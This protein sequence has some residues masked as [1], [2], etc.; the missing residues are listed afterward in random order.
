VSCAPGFL[1]LSKYVAGAS[2]NILTINKTFTSGKLSLL[3]KGNKIE[4][5]YDGFMMY[6][7]YD[8]F[9]N[10]AT[11]HGLYSR[12]DDPTFKW[13]NLC[14]KPIDFIPFRINEDF[15]S[16]LSKWYWT[17]ETPAQ[18]YSQTFST[19]IK[20][21]GSQSFRVELRN[22][23]PDV[24]SSKRCEILL[25]SEQPLEEHWYGVSIYLPNGGTEDYAIDTQ[26]EAL[27][28]WHNTP[29]TSEQSVSPP[30]SLQT[31]N[32]RYNIVIDS[33]AGR[34]S[35]QSAPFSLTQTITDIGDYTADKG[36]WVQWVFHVRWG[37]LSNQNPITEVYKDGLLVYQNNGTPN[38]MN[39]QLGV[40]QKLGIYKWPWHSANNGGSILTSRVVYYDNYWMI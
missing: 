28:Q 6:Q 18:S 32:G 17:K 1:Q 15:E 38:T 34:M 31:I 14:F 35:T 8:S 7:G 12:G 21:S 29:D 24:A 23:D 26:P 9:N 40:Y 33:D 22:T 36:K 2:T 4:I 39:D 10:T 5:Y 25:P 19:G 13:D 3:L 16:N 30:L 11:K 37:W 20:E 27:I